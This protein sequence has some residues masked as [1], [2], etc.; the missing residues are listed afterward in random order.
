MPFTAD[1]H[2]ILNFPSNC[3]GNKDMYQKWILQQ[4]SHVHGVTVAN[5]RDYTSDFLSSTL[6]DMNNLR[7]DLRQ[8]SEHVDTPIENL[9]PCRI[10]RYYQPRNLHQVQRVEGF[11]SSEIPIFNNLIHRRTLSA[12]EG[13]DK[14]TDWKPR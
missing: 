2:R 1:E 13:R 5:W 3:Q 9:Q 6:L 11:F 14:T 7:T 8:P 12:N 4:N 10:G